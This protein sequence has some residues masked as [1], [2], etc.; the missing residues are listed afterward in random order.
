MSFRNITN[1][2]HLVNHCT[3]KDVCNVE[4]IML[5]MLG[6]KGVLS[7]RHLSTEHLEEIRH[8]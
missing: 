6:T 1:L 7:R 4:V 5:G 3:L 2:P 8:L